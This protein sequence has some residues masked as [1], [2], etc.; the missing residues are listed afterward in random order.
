MELIVNN[1]SEGEILKESI[2]SGMRYMREDG[3]EKVK[4]GLTSIEELLRVMS[5]EGEEEGL[6]CRNCLKSL[7]PD[8][9][10]C[11]YCGLSVAN[12]CTRCGRTRESE[13][14]YCPY[15]REEFS[16]VK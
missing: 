10:T 4:L 1:A 16:R 6:L 2:N 3:I 12:K 11:P 7:K 15:C 5:E 14:S 9:L 8:F 13:W